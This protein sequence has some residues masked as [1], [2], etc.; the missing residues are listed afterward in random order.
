MK[1]VED[2]EILRYLMENRQYTPCPQK[3]AGIDRE[4]GDFGLPIVAVP[5]TPITELN[6]TWMGVME[7]CYLFHAHDQKVLIHIDGTLRGVLEKIASTGIDCVDAATPKPVGDVPVSELRKRA[8]PD[9][10]IRTV[11]TAAGNATAAGYRHR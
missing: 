11:L 4:Y 8:G 5:G 9:R 1:D 2:L 3:L 10:R 7:M 6:K